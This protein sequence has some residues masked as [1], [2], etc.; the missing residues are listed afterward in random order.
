MTRPILALCCAALLVSCAKDNP[1]H[2]DSDKKCQDKSWEHYDVAKPECH[3]VGHF[4]YEGC[5]SS[6]DCAD[7]SKNWY[8]PGRSVCDPVSHDCVPGFTMPKIDLDNKPRQVDKVAGGA[9]VDMGA[10]EVQ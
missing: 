5:T 6:A 9:K 1:L 2:C 10:F 8:V 7:T 3:E 4:C